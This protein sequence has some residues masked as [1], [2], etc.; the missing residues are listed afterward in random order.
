MQDP[1]CREGAEEGELPPPSLH[2]RYLGTEERIRST[3][4]D[5]CP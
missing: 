5:P 1:M 3:L 2:G 4:C